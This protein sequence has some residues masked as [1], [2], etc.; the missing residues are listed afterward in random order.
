MIV[1]WFKRQSLMTKL[2]TGSAVIGMIM[3]VVGTM[4]VTNLKAINENTENLYEVQ[5]NAV[6]QAL[7][8]QNNLSMVRFWV[9]RAVTA[10][11]KAHQEASLAKIA[12][13]ANRT[14][15]TR[16]SSKKQLIRMRCEKRLETS[17]TRFRT[18]ERIG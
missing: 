18:I 1:N 4:G 15:R 11:D 3:T 12:E 14:T 17:T 2:M 6:R 7:T 13:L 16:R 9:L 10:P 8:I 5:L